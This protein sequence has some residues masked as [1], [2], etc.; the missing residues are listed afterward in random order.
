MK[1]IVFALHGCP[2]GR[3]GLYGNELAATPNLDRVAA[4]GVVFDRHV[5]DCPDPAAARRAWRTGR[6]QFPPAPPAGAEAAASPPGGVPTPGEPDRNPPDLLDLLRGR[7]VH[8]ILIRANRPQN[9]APSEFYAGWAEVFDARPEPAGGGR[10]AALHAAL[11]GV[12]DRL[13]AHPDWLLW[14]E[15]DRFLP[16]WEVPQ[17]VFEVYVDDL[18]ES[19][20]DDGSPV[21]SARADD[22]TE[23][24]GDDGPD[25]PPDEEGEEEGEGADEDA[26]EI[27][28]EADEE[29]VG[30]AEEAEPVEPWTDPTPGWF[31][32]DDLASWELLHRSLAA[33]TTTFDADLG[34]VFDRLRDRGL[35]DAAW[36]VTS[37]AGYPLGEHGLIGPF[38]PWLHEEA[39]HVP[40]VVRLPG[41]AGAGMRSAALTQPAD[42]APTLLGLFGVPAPLG[43]DGHDLRPLWDGT[44]DAVRPC[45]VS[46]WAVG[47]AAEWAIRTPDWA[48]LLPAAPHPDDDPRPVM[49]FEKPDDRW[50]VN[51]LR[52]RHLEV[53]EELE[54]RLR[55]DAAAR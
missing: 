30:P 37:D 35:A 19:E 8:T 32:A 52:S 26:D 11:P 51:D 28:D 46:G 4:E 43:L 17:D 53:A 7:G 38:R 33:A 42:L 6:H 39:V 49:L 40:L 25:G 55:Q 10:A 1:T 34:D 3:L 20:G 36:V 23:S 29:D 16:P 41:A 50:E 18:I 54:A 31:D 9:D 14:I 22:A 12:L 15:T 48:L 45:A 5:S 27:E 2:A 47:P 13:A 21:E 24:E 44:A